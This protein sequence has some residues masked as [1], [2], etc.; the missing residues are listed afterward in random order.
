MVRGKL[1]A[2]M[3]VWLVTRWQKGRF[4]NRPYGRLA[5]AWIPVY[6]GMTV[7][8]MVSGT[9]NHKGC[10]YDGLAGEWIPAFAGMTVRGGGIGDGQPQGL[11]LREVGRGCRRESDGRPGRVAPTMG[12]PGGIF[13][14][15]SPNRVIVAGVP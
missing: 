8:G 13:V 10:P 12:W 3:T 4:A 5:G 14:A 6:A 2:G 1:Y 11:P 7:G 9:G 15:I